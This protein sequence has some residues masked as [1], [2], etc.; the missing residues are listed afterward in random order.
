MGPPRVT[1]ELLLR[2][3]GG[4]HWE[5]LCERHARHLDD[6][7]GTVGEGVLGCSEE[8]HPTSGTGICDLGGLVCVCV[9]GRG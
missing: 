9:G 5:A 2:R 3:E 7:D 1:L 4:G 8:G 6:V